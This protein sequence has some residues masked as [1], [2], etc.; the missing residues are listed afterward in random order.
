M[1]S[2]A[3]VVEAGI[4]GGVFGVFS[5]GIEGTPG[6]TLGS[7]LATCGLLAL[8]TFSVPEAGVFDAAVCEADGCGATLA[9]VDALAPGIIRRRPARML[10]GLPS[11]F[12][13]MI[14]V[15]PTWYIL[16]IE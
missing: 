11:P 6:M 15:G 5:T 7:F 9:T 2:T 12:A 8:G 1:L 3:V 10:P 13:A 4:A 16:P 14:S